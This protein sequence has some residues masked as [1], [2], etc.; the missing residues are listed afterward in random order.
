MLRREK[1]SHPP[2]RAAT[3]G[4]VSSWVLWAVGAVVLFIAVAVVGEEVLA[5]AA[6]RAATEAGIVRDFRHFTGEELERDVRSQVPL[7]SS[8]ALV[9][10]FLAR[11]GMKFSY[12]SSL[13]ATLAK[14][15][16]LKGSGIVVKSL[17]LTFRFDNESKLV[18]I[19]AQVH[20]TGP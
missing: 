14:A 7:S 5:R 8:R 3:A 19:E 11:E 1:S 16:C 10:S 4:K 15:P 9:E 6:C 18:S 12:S 2:S 13:H 17:G 20:L